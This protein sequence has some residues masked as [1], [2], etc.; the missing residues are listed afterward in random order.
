MV[1]FYVEVCKNRTMYTVSQFAK[2]VG[3]SVKTRQI[4]DRIGVLPAPLNKNW[5]K[6]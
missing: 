4:G 2:K 1:I 3:V 6:I 5:C